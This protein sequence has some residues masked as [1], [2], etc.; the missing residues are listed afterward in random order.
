MLFSDTLQTDEDAH[1][2]E[3][4]HNPASA[5]K[6]EKVN[7]PECLMDYL[8]LVKAR[9]QRLKALERAH[10]GRSQKYSQREEDYIEVI[11]ELI[12]E[13]GYA[14][15]I[16]ISNNLN[17]QAPTVTGMVQRLHAN[18]LLQYEK[19]RGI[20]LTEKGEALARSIRKRHSTVAEFLMILGVEERLAHK[21][22]EGIE[23][24]L[25]PQT[26]EK[27]TRFV[28]FVRSDTDM[29]RKIRQGIK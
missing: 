23:H 26:L 27:L 25:H 29:L 10:L 5:I 11:Y 17:V 19:Y 2:P 7:T 4:R 9:S 18:G 14:R 16:D 3:F 1:V 12:K 6:S 24:N 22:A 20:V 21:D 15:T 28:R 13:K 8:N